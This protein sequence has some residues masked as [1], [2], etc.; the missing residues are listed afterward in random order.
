MMSGAFAQ[1]N[2]NLDPVTVL[3]QQEATNAGAQII[4][5]LELNSLKAR[6]SDTASLIMDIPGAT[7]NVGGGV[8][9]LPSIHGMADDRLNTSING[10]DLISSCQP[11]ELTFVVCRS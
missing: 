3:G 4:K 5:G 6:T 10:I 8:S 11:Y 2:V 1:S 7:V 9:G